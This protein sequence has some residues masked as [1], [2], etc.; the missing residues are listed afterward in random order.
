MLVRAAHP[1]SRG[2][3]LGTPSPRHPLYGSS[4]LTRG[5]LPGGGYPETL[6]GL[7][8][9]HAGKTGHQPPP[10]GRHSAHPRSRGENRTPTAASG[11]ALGSSPLTRGKPRWQHS[12]S[13]SA[14]LIPAH[15]GKTRSRALSSTARQAHPRSRGE[16][17]LRELIGFSDQGSSPLTRGKPHLHRGPGHPGRLIPAHAGKTP[18]SHAAALRP[19]AH[20]R[21]RGENSITRIKSCTM[22]GSSPLTRGKQ[23]V[24]P[25]GPRD[26]RLIPAHAGKTRGCS[27]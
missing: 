16:N 9:A 23:A 21:S 2:E 27:P 3:N 11:P 8:P 12:E 15:A 4:P 18:H 10:P 13:Q 7:I 25:L 14:G 26:E 5:K 24:R 6:V 20:P 22:P 19:A 1:R 17:E